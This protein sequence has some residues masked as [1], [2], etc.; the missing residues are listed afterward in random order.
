[1]DDDVFTWIKH[2]QN[3]ITN[4]AFKDSIHT[5]A[6]ISYRV[7]TTIR[8]SRSLK[9]FGKGIRFDVAIGALLYVL[10]VLRQIPIFRI[11]VN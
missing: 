4:L 1:M 8:K 6:V 7:L 5:K 2:F 10:L 3:R 11:K 9:N